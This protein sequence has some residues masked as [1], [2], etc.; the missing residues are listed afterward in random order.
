[1]HPILLIHNFFGLASMDN[2]TEGPVP[3]N[4][5]N[6]LNQS[7]KR[8]L[9]KVLA[10]SAPAVMLLAHRPA[11]G[12]ICTLSGFGS[13][14]AGTHL[15]H[16]PDQTTPC[17]T[18]SHGGWKTVLSGD[19][20]WAIA[21]PVTPFYLF[22]DIFTSANSPVFKNGKVTEWGITS[23]KKRA[24]IDLIAASF[25]TTYTPTPAGGD[26]IILEVL[27]KG[28]VL[29]R[30][31]V[32]AYLNAVASENIGQPFFTPAQIIELWNYRQSTTASGEVVPLTP[33]TDLELIDLLS[34]SYH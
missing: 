20:D 21:A 16:H 22:K 14:Q 25:S 26:P 17:N 15:S 11:F 6:D 8:K 24:E 9:I 34:Q 2:R 4:T 29:S 7:S 30:E 33:M 27:I 12:Q 3:Q 13:I 1:M 23:A 5:S 28:D 10:T 32:N 19:P 18:Y 31:I